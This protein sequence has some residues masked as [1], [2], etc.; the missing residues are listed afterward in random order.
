MRLWRL[1]QTG[2]T[3]LD[4]RGTM[5][6][7]GRYSPPGAPVVNFASEAGLA[8]LVTLRYMRG[9]PSDAP[10]DYVLGWTEIDAIP[11]RVPDEGSGDEAIRAWVNEWLHERRSLLA[12]VRSQVLPEADV[13]LMN[14]LHPDATR[15]PPLVTRPFSFA[16]CLH[17]PPMLSRYVG[18]TD[19]PR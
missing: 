13:V 1:T 17:T 12:A 16:D 6:H 5:K 8:V 10:D 19:T 15:V 9:N 2:H 11:E 14:P 4:G 7:G 3:A 18:E